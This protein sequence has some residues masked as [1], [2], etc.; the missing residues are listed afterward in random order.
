MTRLLRGLIFRLVRLF[1]PHIEVQHYRRLP[2]QGPVLFVLNHPNGLLDPLVLM[3][4]LRQPVAFLAKST[5]FTNPIGRLLMH[6]FGA[7]PVYRH[8]DKGQRGGPRGDLRAHNEATFARCRQLLRQDGALALFPEGTTHSEPQLLRVR[9]GAARIGLSAEAETNW[10]LGLQIVPVGLWYEDKTRFRSNV[11][12]VV[13][14]PFTLKAYAS[15]HTTDEAAAV[16][17]LTYRIDDALDAVVLQATHADL[18]TAIPA[19]A[20]WT[21]PTDA[22]PDL[23]QQHAW[24]TTLLAAHDWLHR[25]HP[26]RLDAIAAEAR[27]Y[28]G[29]LDELG[30]Q[31]PWSL[32]RPPIQRSRLIGGILALIASSPFALAGWLMSYGPYRLAGLV[33]ERS[34]RG[35]DALVGTLK[36][37]LGSVFVLLG[38]IL[39]A[40]VVGGLFGWW[41]GALVLA[42]A[43]VLGY[44]ALRWGERWRRLR[45]RAAHRALHRRH[46]SLVDLLNERRQSL[47]EH[48]LAAVEAMQRDSAPPSMTKR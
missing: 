33:A 38:W 29:L 45:E 31:T 5:F 13:G 40:S 26:D 20:A 44:I 6:A 46:S 25:T 42:A 7:L 30:V 3:V 41:W 47:T 48:V 12:L 24:A 43:P 27:R 11:L 4:A 2:E 10:T 36:L 21:S 9:T 22:A 37:I 15:T 8:R 39:E 1:Y 18:L 28:A 17:S 34:V 32:E 16:R 35:V 19:L 23:S 14:N